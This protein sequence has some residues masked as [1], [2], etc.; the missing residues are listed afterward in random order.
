MTTT[1]IGSPTQAART[2]LAAV[3]SLAAFVFI[4]GMPW[5]DLGLWRQTEVPAALIHFAAALVTFLLG[6]LIFKK[7]AETAGLFRHPA[8]LAIIGLALFTAAV[9]PFTESP[10]RSIHGTLKHGIGALWH[11]ELA[12][13]IVASALVLRSRAAVIFETLL[14]LST[15]AV[16]ALYAFP[17]SD[18]VGWPMSFPEWVGLLAAA[19]SFVIVSRS[20]QI[21][22][23]RTVIALALLAGGIY[24]SENRAVMLSVAACLIV[25][26]ACRLPVLSAWFSSPRFRAAFVVTAGLVGVAVMTATAPLIEKVAMS[27]PGYSGAEMILSDNPL[28]RHALQ[29]GALG[30]LWSRSHMVLMVFG[31]IVE[32]PSKLIIGQGWGSF[33]TVYEY[34]A[35]EVPGRLFPTSLPTASLTYWDAQK[36]SDFHSHDLPVE[37]LLSGGVVAFVLW[38]AAIGAVA[39]TSRTGLVGATGVMVGSLFWFPVNHMTIAIA[40]LL[41]CGVAPVA[42]SERAL[43]VASTAIAIPVALAC[44]LFM[45]AGAQ[46]FTLAWVEHN[47]RYF[48]PIEADRNPAT[49]SSIATVML[50]ED[51]VNISLYEVLTQRIL[52]SSNRPKEVYERTTNLLTLT[53]TLRSYYQNGDNIRA[54]VASLEKRAV[55]VGIGPASYGP[56]VDDIVNWGKDVDRLLAMAPQR[57]EH[58]VPYLSAL[59]QR[60]KNKDLILAELDRVIAKLPPSDPVTVYVEAM[61][62]RQVGDNAGYLEKLKKAVSMGYANIYSMPLDKAK[63]LGLK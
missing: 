11:L 24:V 27:T 8:V 62:A 53:C 31:D 10:W 23:L 36:M 25:V 52:R 3:L 19:V 33:G 9:A 51:E 54:L 63:E 56:M 26:E 21:F 37:A 29:N 14:V 22:S 6:F 42:V 1:P 28:D 38:F 49:C 34:H 58:V 4:F 13:F 5:N 41:A 32:H 48:R 57:T 45:T 59:V 40:A 60:S 15:S 55:L 44:A 2:A 47:E 61:R 35:R 39:A 30:T 12:L 20:R 17:E 50:P 16:I 46:M 18:L 7:D 43:K